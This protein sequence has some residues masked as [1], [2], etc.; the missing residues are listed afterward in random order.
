[1]ATD[2]ATLRRL[3]AE[4]GLDWVP[5]ETTQAGLSPLQARSRL[6]ADPPGGRTA[7]RLR[8]RAALANLAAENADG[9]ATA[10]LATAAPPAAFD[11]RDVAGASY[12]SPVRD[13][14]GCGSCVA[15]GTTATLESMVRIAAKDPG[16]SVD[17]SEAYVFFCLGPHHGAGRCPD[18]GWWVDQALTAMK[19]GVTDEANYPYTDSDQP[20]RRGSDW[21]SRRTRFS[22]WVSKT[23]PT[24][25]KRYLATIGPMVACFTVHEDFFYYTGG[26]Y[27][28]HKKTSGD[29]VGGHCVQVVGYD[30]AAQCWIAKNS[31]GTGWGEDGCFRIGYG[32][33]GIDAE[34]WGIDGTITSPLVRKTLQVVL[35]GSGDVWRTQRS[36]SGTWKRKPE[37]L[38]TG[39]PGDPGTVTAVTA[40]ATI[41]RL[42]VLAL[43]GGTAWYT[44]RRT[45][46]G[47]AKWAEPGS[48]RPAGTGAWT[49]ISCAT[50]GD[51]LHV[52]ALAGGAVWH[53]RRT[54][55][56]TWQEAWTR[57]AAATGTPGPFTALSCVVVGT[58]VTV[59]GIAGGSLWLARRKGNGSWT[60]PARVTPATGQVPTP[61]TAVGAASVDGRLNVVALGAGQAWHLER[62]GSTWSAWQQVPSTAPAA[63]FTGLACAGLGPRLQVLALADGRFW[64][65]QRRADGTWAATFADAGAQLTGTPAVLDWADGA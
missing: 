28:Y 32:V 42:H 4:V 27:R 24:A 29:F 52:V 33:T 41:N 53:T 56:G 65:T 36:S 48:T 19:P 47:W 54:A 2:L 40:A 16:L 22:S 39:T 7:L 45:G 63:P 26:V 62:V 60:A 49:T 44:R 15:F 58:T 1:M 20:C 59:V 43:V 31:W 11:W 30:D 37:R 21:K 8:E 14:A 3:V 9:A 64:F 51:A 5:G 23:S 38:D 50:A 18:G 6:G 12:V 55:S 57:V 17:L 34:M 35:A 25:M 13:Q 61:L 10:R 46:A